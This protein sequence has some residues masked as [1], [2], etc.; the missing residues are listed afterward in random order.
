MSADPYS[1]GILSL[2]AA[3]L[4]ALFLVAFNIV[5]GVIAV[6]MAKKRDIPTTPAFFAGLFGGVLSL[7]IIA[8][9]PKKE[10]V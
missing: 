2:V 9:F 8:F 6:S 1:F 4:P 5:M 3:L 10:Q 7:C